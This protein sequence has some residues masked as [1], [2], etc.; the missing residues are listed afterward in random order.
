MPDLFQDLAGFFLFELPILLLSP[1]VIVL[2]MLFGYLGTC[3]GMGLIVIVC[4][5]S[6][7]EM[8]IAVV[9]YVAFLVIFIV[10]RDWLL[11]KG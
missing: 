6:C 8:T 4:L 7:G 10:G 2:E 11:G 1:F 9:N 5:F 3:L